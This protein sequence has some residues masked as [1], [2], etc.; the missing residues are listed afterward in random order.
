MRISLPALVVA[1]LFSFN[2]GVLPSV[3]A[4]QKI[5]IDTDFNTIGDDGQVLVMAAQLQAAGALDIL[6]LTIPTGNQWRDQEISDALKAVERLGIEHKVRIHPGT[7]YPLLH[8]YKSYLYEKAVFAGSDYVGAYETPPPTQI[9]APPD[10]FATH[11]VPSK[12]DA[13]D[14]I[15]RSLHRYP[16]E[17][18]LLTIGPLT[19][20]ALAI[21]KDPSIVPLIK[22][23][24]FMGG[25]IDVAGN[26]FNDVGEFNWWM[27]AEAVQV[28]LRANVPHSI[29]PLDCTNTVPLTKDVYD[30]IANTPNPTSVTKLFKDA[31]AQFFGPNPPS[32]VAY[33]Y[34]TIAVTYAYDPSFARQT[35]D[36]YVDIDTNFSGDYGH[37]IGYY[38]NLPTDPLQKCLVIQRIHKQRFYDFY[39]DLLTRPVPVQREGDAALASRMTDDRWTMTD[40][41]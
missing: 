20:V 15:I 18:T 26:A 39:V 34:D 23:I 32:Y 6:G 33:I 41:E 27:D 30:R 16:Q 17:I 36:R 38:N 7:Q 9:V 25:Q 11:T 5:I 31:F 10:G 21:R 29:V 35:Q 14:F 4:P 3:A 28:V 22:R 12:V 2:I 40:E 19:N 24:V 13:V 8:D 1:A 37:A